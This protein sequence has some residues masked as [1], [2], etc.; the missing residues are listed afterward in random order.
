MK[1]TYINPTMVTV[2]IAS[3]SQMLAGSNP[4]LGSSFQSGETVLGR[5]SDDWDDE[6]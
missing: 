3:K 1:K 2:K 5:E 6:D 4:G